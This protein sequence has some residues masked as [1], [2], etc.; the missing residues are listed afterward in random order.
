MKIAVPREVADGETRTALTPSVIPALLRAGHQ[1]I[2]ESGA[3]TR[4][5]VSDDAYMCAGA[6]P[7][8][9]LFALYKDAEVV[10]KVQPPQ[11]QHPRTN[12]SEAALIGE[13]ATYIGM[14]SPFTRPDVAE[15]FAQRRVT[16]YAMELIPRIARAQS[17]DALSSMATIAG[18]KSVLLAAEHLG[19]MMPLM[20]TA[21]GTV[22]PANVLVL[23]AGVAGLQ[24][25]AT[26]RRLGARV[27]AFDA[28]PVVRDQVRSLGATFIEMELAEGTETAGGYA[29]EQSADFLARE[30]ATVS[31][32]L[33][34]MNV[35]ITTAQVFGKR[36]PTL[37]TASMVGLMRAG[38]VV[39]D[40]AAEQGGNCELTRPGETVTAQD[41]TILGPL[42]VPAM[43][44][45]DASEMYAHNV[46]SLLR[47]LFP[48]DQ[49]PP[50]ST[51][52]I[53]AAACVTHGGEIVN[54]LVKQVVGDQSK[55]E[56]R[57]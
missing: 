29:K 40:L 23:G 30:M 48:Q 39:V 43:M 17:M 35:V 21:A 22:A 12:S 53:V 10:V 27:L 26:A 46:A 16:S 20:M 50:D 52:E 56:A 8:A 24:A 13:G 4:A 19:K 32:H 33:P 51:D 18:Y 28:R 49:P 3:G 15:I 47:Y 57:L 45:I 6:Q 34:E 9:D 41:V 37:L 55:V 25:I 14:L 31:A 44:P 2:F 11:E 7:A 54:E 36:A 38:S 5:F 42:N 1:V